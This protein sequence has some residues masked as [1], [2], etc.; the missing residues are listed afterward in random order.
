MDEIRDLNYQS[1]RDFTY[2]NFG[3]EKFNSK[4]FS[5]DASNDLFSSKNELDEYAKKVIGGNF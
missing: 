2:S 1:S 3:D 5:A 4:Q